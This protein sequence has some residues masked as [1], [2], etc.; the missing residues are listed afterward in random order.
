MKTALPPHMSCRASPTTVVNHIYRPLPQTLLINNGL[1]AS[2]GHRHHQEPQQQQQLHLLQQQLQQQQKQ[3]PR[4][5]QQLQQQQQQQKIQAK[6]DLQ[7][8]RRRSF[9]GER[10]S[11][12]GHV[13]GD[14]RLLGSVK[15][16]KTQ[17]LLVSEPAVKQLGAAGSRHRAP[18]VVSASSEAHRFRMRGLVSSKSSENFLQRRRVSMTAVS[19]GYAPAKNNIGGGGVLSCFC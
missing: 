5:Q 15:L 18:T 12:S 7:D 1:K 3:Q 14:E 16:P 11:D 4:Q 19:R 10:K 9:G 13:G 6:K 8:L 2:N 17:P